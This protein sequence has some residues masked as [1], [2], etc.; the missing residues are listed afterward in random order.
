MATR[1]KDSFGRDVA[2]RI[3]EAIAAVH[4]AFPTQAFLEDALEGFDDLELTARARQIARALRTHLPDDYETALAILVASLGPPI[5]GDE[6]SGME[7]FMYLPHVYFVA[8]NGVNHWEASMAA[9]YE[10]TK[11]ST[12]E[13]SIR[14]FLVHEPDRTLARLRRW[15]TDPNPHVRRL[16]SEGTRPRLPWA[17][18]LPAFQRD[19]AP[20][21]ELLELLKDDPSLYVRRSVANNLNDI[22]KD[23][24]DVLVETCGRWLDGAD[25]GRLWL[26]RHA[27][28]SAVKRGDPRALDLLGFAA[29]PVAEIVDVAIT[30]QAARIG[31]TVR[32]EFTVRNAGRATARVN[33]DVRVHFV[34]SRGTTSPKVFKVAEVTIEPGAEASLAKSIS[35]RQHT[36]RTHFPGE[37]RVEAVV[38][39]ATRPLG[40]F[41]VERRGKATP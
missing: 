36:T 23:H 18:R 12:A 5:D 38:N 3:R 26:V 1:L 2:V 16:V 19:P 15:A 20:V 33:V 7:A 21:I 11:R 24:P 39:G 34:K 32:L 27:L 30:P 29:D 4:P 10:L 9:Q 37:H 35:L 31:D 17:P 25:D 41:T 13:F 6:L 22:G 14:A 28:R 8:E 40:T